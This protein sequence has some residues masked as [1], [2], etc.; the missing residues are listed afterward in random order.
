MLNEGIKIRSTML[1]SVDKEAKQR[2]LACHGLKIGT[3]R[4]VIRLGKLPNPGTTLIQVIDR[5]EMPQHR[6]CAANLLERPVKLGKIV[7]LGGVA[8]ECVK[9]LL[10]LCQI[11]LDFAGDLANQQFFL[12]SPGHFVE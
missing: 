9:R 12:G 2:K 5:T 4:L 3:D 1:Q 11:V 6:Q 10:D 8:E 7:S